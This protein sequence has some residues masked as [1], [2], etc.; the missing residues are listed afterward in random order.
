MSPI[1]FL[2]VMRSFQQPKFVVTILGGMALWKLIVLTWLRPWMI[3]ILDSKC[4][5]CEPER[6]HHDVTLWKHFPRYWPF[7][8]GLHRSLVNPPPPPPPPKGQWRGAFLFSLICTLKKRLSKQSW[9]WWFETPSRSLWHHCNE[10]IRKELTPTMFYEAVQIWVDV[11]DLSSLAAPEVV[12]KTAFGASDCKNPVLWL[13][14]NFNVWWA[15]NHAISGPEIHKMS[16]N[17]ALSG[18]A[19][20]VERRLKPFWARLMYLGWHAAKPRRK[21]RNL[22]QDVLYQ[23]SNLSICLYICT[24]IYYR[25]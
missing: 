15:L 22:R 13:P 6:K 12:N 9:G 14:L 19:I 23:D 4:L 5:Y 8:R 3:T 7:L 11:I 10:A 20:L 21:Q 17:M 1:T 18:L 24:C 25:N 16:H 2:R